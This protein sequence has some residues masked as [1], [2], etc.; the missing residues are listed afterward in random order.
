MFDFS[1]WAE[2][3]LKLQNV[4][5]ALAKYVDR[6]PQFT[7]APLLKDVVESGSSVKEEVFFRKAQ[8]QPDKP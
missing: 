2:Q 1:W 3:D 6:L 7:I 4:A 5:L 8:Q